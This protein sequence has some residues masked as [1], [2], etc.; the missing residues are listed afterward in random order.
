VLYEW[1]AGVI[2]RYVCPMKVFDSPAVRALL[3][4]ALGLVVGVF[5]AGSGAP[6]GLA[7]A[8]IV[9]PVGTLWV[10]ALRMTVVPLVISL[11]IST[12]ASSAGAAMFG[13]LGRRALLVFL[14]FL[15]GM[16]IVGLVTAI[17]IYSRLTVDPAAAASLRA[18][19]AASM[20]ATKPPG[21]AAWFTSLVPANVVQSASDGAML[22]LIIFA[23]IFGLALGRVQDSQRDAL[24]GFFRAIAGA[25]MAI[26][27]W[28]LLLAPIG[29]FALAV[30]VATHLGNA[31]AHVILFYLL[32]HCALLA[33]L[34][35][36]IYLIVPAI[37]RTPIRRFAR[38]LLP[39]QV[40]AVTTRSSL[41]ALPVMLDKAVTVLGVPPAVASFVLPLGVS[42]LRAQTGLSYVVYA[43]FLGKLYGIP[44]GVSQLVFVAAVGI[45]MSFS[46][47]GIP[48]GGLLIATPYFQ[49]IGLPAQGIGILIAL[50]AIPD[51]FKTLVIVQ[52]HMSTTLII[53][54]AETPVGP[55]AG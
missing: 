4:L 3:G 46:V 9:E 12:L 42:L 16:A 5:I 19:A 29:A 52:S 37:T 22:P 38:A 14:A 2:A 45:A 36:M 7:F 51:I 55:S 33:L 32:S 15:V 47:P 43:L 13:Q 11:I 26:V 50:D 54:R 31:T 1:Q 40:V 8:S 49:A 41:A 27:Q 21:F 10:N 6:A 48:S 35:V 39:A 25:M 18:T 34:A 44:L 30:T 23:I 53:A 28:V 17:P 20:P 24:T